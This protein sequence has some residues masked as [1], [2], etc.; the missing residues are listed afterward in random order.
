[1]LPEIDRERVWE[2]KGFGS[3]SEYAGKLSGMSRET[4]SEGLRVLRLV[5]GMPDIMEVVKQRGINCVKPIATL[6]TPENQK[7][8]AEKARNMSKNTLE[9]YVREMK[10]QHDPMISEEMW[11]SFLQ[12]DRLPR[13]AETLD[14]SYQKA[15]K[16]GSHGCAGREVGTVTATVTT[17][18]LELEP[19]VASTLTKLKGRDGDWNTLMKELLTMREQMLEQ[20]KFEITKG[21]T[22]TAPV[23]AVGGSSSEVTPSVTPI[24]SHHIPQRSRGSCEMGTC[25]KPSLILHH[26]QRFAL[27]PV[28]RPDHIVALCKGHERMVHL[29]LIEDE[30][31]KPKTWKVMAEADRD[32]PKYHID[33]MVQRY[34]KPG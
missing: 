3:L 6:L 15:I 1:M 26:V 2:K 7:F 21:G 8:W 31:M 14:Y 23:V 29:G 5:E 9:L 11:L 17:L 4:V 22:S 32:D 24:A 19:E 18:T 28:H 10:S 12:D 25:M 30:F 16:I 34:R 20:K 13:K 33:Q 27:E